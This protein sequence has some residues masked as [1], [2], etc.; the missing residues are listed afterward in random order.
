METDLRR[1]IQWIPGRVYDKTY[2]RSSMRLRWLLHGNLGTIQF[3]MYTGWLPEHVDTRAQFGPRVDTS[4]PLPCR[5][6]VRPIQPD[7]MASDLG[8]HWRAP[9]SWM[10]EGDARSDCD[11]FGGAPCFYDGSGLNAEPVMAALFTDGDEA[12]WSMMA[13]YY[14]DLAAAVNA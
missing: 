5:D 13:D 11:L 14:A 7:P 1:E 12:V 8:F 10:T 3:V 9:V 6:G 2:G 4:R